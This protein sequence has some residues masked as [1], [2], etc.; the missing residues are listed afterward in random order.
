MALGRCSG[1]QHNN[2]PVQS[3]REGRPFTAQQVT[4][5][6]PC[7]HR[8]TIKSHTHSKH[9][10]HTQ[11][12]QYNRTKHALKARRRRSTPNTTKPNTH[13]TMP[14][15]AQNHAHTGTQSN[16]THTQNIQYNQTKHALK[17]RRRRPTHPIHSTKPNTHKNTKLTKVNERWD[18]CPRK[19]LL[20]HLHHGL[21]SLRCCWL[22]SCSCVLV[23]LVK[24]MGERRRRRSKREKERKCTARCMCF[25]VSSYF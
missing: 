4:S 23:C 24:Q 3:A 1:L 8:H 19:H 25:G 18:V 20:G 10:I 22:H 16:H 12:I 11:N 17:A 13:K 2:T 15:Q 21:H 14:T 6:K 9:P 5:A 7:P